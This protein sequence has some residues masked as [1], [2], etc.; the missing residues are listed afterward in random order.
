MYVDLLWAVVSLGF[1]LVFFQL[2]FLVLGGFLIETFPSATSWPWS[3][4]NVAEAGSREEE[5][6]GQEKRA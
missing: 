3:I 6:C 4:I 1:R 2:F 5:I